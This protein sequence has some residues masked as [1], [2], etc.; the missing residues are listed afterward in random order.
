MR[1]DGIRAEV[2]LSVG[3]EPGAEAARLGEKAGPRDWKAILRKAP[4]SRSALVA[5][6][7]GKQVVGLN[8]LSPLVLGSRGDC[9][10]FLVSHS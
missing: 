7:S 9:S 5:P 1:W 2:G 10:W 6:F 4:R 3:R 8:G